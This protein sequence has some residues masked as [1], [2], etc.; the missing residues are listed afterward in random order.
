MQVGLAELVLFMQD[1]LHASTLALRMLHLNV[2][3]QLKG[4]SK[5][6]PGFNACDRPQLFQRLQ[7]PPKLRDD[8]SCPI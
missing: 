3:I 4:C 1:V 7:P 8:I 6:R 2:P 5:A